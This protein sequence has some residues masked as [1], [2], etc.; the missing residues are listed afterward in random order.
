MKPQQFQENVSEWVIIINNILKE[1][2]EDVEDIAMAQEED[3]Q[4]LSYQYHIIKDLRKRMVRMEREFKP[5][6]YL[7]REIIFLKRKEAE[8]VRS[9]TEESCR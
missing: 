9:N 4:T 2:R 1:L 6:K 5:L 3:L 7:T 8:N